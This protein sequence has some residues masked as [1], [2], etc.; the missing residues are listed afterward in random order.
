MANAILIKPNQV[1]SLSETLDTV[2]L[3]YEHDYKAIVSH[4]SGETG[5][6]FIADLAVALGCGHI[7]AGSASRSDR[8][9]KYNRLL[10]IQE[11]GI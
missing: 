9:E 11:D 6:S 1:G 2:A 4:R 3:A 7:K 10:R 5:D 8:L